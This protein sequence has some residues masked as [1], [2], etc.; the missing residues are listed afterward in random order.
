[1]DRWRVA[2]FVLCVADWIALA[3]VGDALPSTQGIRCVLSRRFAGVRRR[4][5]RPA[6]IASFRGTPGLGQQRPPPGRIRRS[7][8]GART[9][10]HLCRLPR[11]GGATAEWLAWRAYLLGSDFPA[12]F[13]IGHR[14]V[15]ILGG[16][17]PALDRASRPAGRERRGGWSVA[18]CALSTSFDLRHHG[19]CGFLSRDFRVPVAIYVEDAALARR[20]P[21]C[22]CRSASSVVLRQHEGRLMPCTRALWSP[23]KSRMGIIVDDD[24]S[25]RRAMTCLQRR[26]EAV[27]K[28]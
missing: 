12:V 18:R 9:V 3:G 19:C 5:R 25:V 4:T 20:D 27:P 11:G 6:S 15:A 28:G 1:M 7:P 13:S 2:C 21:E 14:H 8:G 24:W 17:A 26:P 16:A 10:V 22:G 23:W